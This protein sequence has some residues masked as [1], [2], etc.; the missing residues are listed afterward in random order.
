MSSWWLF[1]ANHTV[2]ENTDLRP[3]LIVQRGVVQFAFKVAPHEWIHLIDMGRIDCALENIGQLLFVFRRQDGNQG[4]RR[5][6]TDNIVAVEDAGLHGLEKV[7]A[8]PGQVSQPV[9][10]GHRVKAKKHDVDRRFMPSLDIIMH[11]GFPLKDARMQTRVDN[12]TP[13]RTAPY[14]EELFVLVQLAA[15]RDRHWLAPGELEVIQIPADH[16]VLTRGHLDAC[17]L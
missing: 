14:Q 15:V 2:L 10:S 4:G 3:V 9:L 6:I 17:L 8:R 11:Q 16:L 12:P 13:H 1:E 7:K 5:A